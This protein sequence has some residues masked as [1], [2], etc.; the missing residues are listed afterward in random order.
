MQMVEGISEWLIAVGCGSTKDLLLSSLRV[1]LSFVVVV[2]DNVVLN[3]GDFGGLS[4]K[5]DLQLTISAPMWWVMPGDL[6]LV[7]N[8]QQS[9]RTRWSWS[10]LGKY[11]LVDVQH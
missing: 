11:L 9:W 5:H 1:P 8:V 7:V 10:E 4:A 3:Q 6:K 2:G